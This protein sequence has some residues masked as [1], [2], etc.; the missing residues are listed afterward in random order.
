M[1]RLKILVGLACLLAPTESC[2]QTGDPR[3]KF[4]ISAEVLGSTGFEQSSLLSGFVQT[5]VLAGYGIGDQQDLLPPL[6]RVAAP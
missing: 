3:E 1:N 2:A 6:R 4:S 5:E